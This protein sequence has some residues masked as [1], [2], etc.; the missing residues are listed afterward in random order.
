[1]DSRQVSDI[2]MGAET[3]WRRRMLL[4][5]RSKHGDGGNA[6][7]GGSSSDDSLRVAPVAG[8][9]RIKLIEKRIS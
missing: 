6:R 3:R 5:E 8:S 2:T 4:I 9:N 1:M 7:A